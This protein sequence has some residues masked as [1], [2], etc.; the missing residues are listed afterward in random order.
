M[1]PFH[2]SIGT[3]V[4]GCGPCVMD[5]QEGH[6]LGPQIRWTRIGCHG[7]MCGGTPKLAIHPGIMAWATVSVVIV[8]RGMASGQWVNL[9]THVSR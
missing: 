4:V 8:V 5:V 3:V 6:E 1:E 7:V 9:S 2:H